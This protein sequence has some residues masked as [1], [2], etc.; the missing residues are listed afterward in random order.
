MKAVEFIEVSKVYKGA[1]KPSL[2]SFSMSIPLGG[3]HGLL[4]PNGAG[5][6]TA[7]GILCGLKKSDAGRVLL[8]NQDISTSMKM[9]RYKIGVVPQDIALFPILSGREN[10]MYFG[11]LYGI[12]EGVLKD[13]VSQLLY[14]FD[15]SSN[16]DK[17]V[18]NYSGGMK[19][20]I[21]LIA[22]VLHNP[23]LL[24]LDEPTVGVD[25]QSRFMIIQFLKEYCK[26]GKTILYTS[27]LMDEAEQL[28]NSVT[29]I[30]GG[31]E[32]I[33]GSPGELIKGTDGV[34]HLE[35]LFLHFT[36]TNVRDF[37]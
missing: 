34:N 9:L 2:D 33:S 37:A 24:V 13:K 25:V 5:K 12:N 3:I 19:R 7:I 32:I 15:L 11:R 31:K 10:L 23:D 28:C 17:R 14:D 36:G 30:D 27:H 16:A 22:G 29:I 1:L 35:D 20:R 26:Q 21:N 18:V 8:F 4:G 6:T